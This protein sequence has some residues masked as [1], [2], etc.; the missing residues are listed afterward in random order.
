[1]SALCSIRLEVKRCSVPFWR[2]G[3]KIGGAMTEDITVAFLAR[4][5]D[6]GLEAIEAFL[7]SYE[8]HAAGAPHALVI[9]AKAWEGV[10]GRDRLGELAAAAG[11]VVLDLPDDGYDWGAYFRLSAIAKTEYLLLLSTHSRILK[12]DWLAL[13]YEQIKRPGIGLV[14]CTGSFGTMGWNWVHPIFRLQVHWYKR[15]LDKVIAYLGW[16][17]VRYFFS[18]FLTGGAS[19]VSQT[20]ISDRTPLCCERR[21]CA[22]SRHNMRCRGRSME[23]II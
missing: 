9:L 17:A 14:G 19:R 13:L 21:I 18:C 2:K 23:R 16:V 3:D 5:V 11:A 15:R 10:P 4:G 22:N 1:M 7:A 8:R 20:H 12:D 6:G